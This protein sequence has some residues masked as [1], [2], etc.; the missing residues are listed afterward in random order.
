[1]AKICFY[2]LLHQPYRINKFSIFDIGNN[3]DEYYDEDLNRQVFSKVSSKSYLPMN[4]LLL[5]LINKTQGKF[6]FSISISGVAIEQ[7]IKYAPEVLKSFQELAKTGNVEFVC[8]TYYNSSSFFYSQDEFERQVQMHKNII[9]K[10]F[11]QKPIIFRNIGLSFNNDLIKSLIKFNFKGLYIDGSNKLSSNINKNQVYQNSGLNVFLKNRTFS[12]DISKRFTDISWS[13]YPLSASKYSK[14]I[15]DN[16]NENSVTNISIPYEVF[17]DHH[18]EESGIFDFF[19]K[20]IQDTLEKGSELVNVG[21]TLNNVDLEHIDLGENNQVKLQNELQS[22]F[23][24]KLYSLEKELF[25]FSD[26]DLICDWRKLTSPDYLAYLDT[27]QFRENLISRFNV[28]GSPY[29]AY[30]YL[31]N[32]LNDMEFKLKMKKVEIE[33][34]N[35]ISRKVDSNEI[36]ITEIKNQ[37]N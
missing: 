21:N 17:G 18:N 31:M 33:K 25:L 2:F 3:I 32:I 37:L 23:M 36:A 19:E 8:T 16:T 24:K 15:T 29:D 28:Y 4:K 13:E 7:M 34:K 30:L 1:M 12:E 35:I 9:E 10:Y 22:D 14:W 5:K 6:K 26:K 11:F 20:L 27:K